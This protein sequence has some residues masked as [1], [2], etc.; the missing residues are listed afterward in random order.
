MYVPKLGL[1]PR[2]TVYLNT[3]ITYGFYQLNYFGDHPS[4]EVMI[5]PFLELAPEGACINAAGLSL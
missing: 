1:E 5:L 4:Y 3:G 2:T